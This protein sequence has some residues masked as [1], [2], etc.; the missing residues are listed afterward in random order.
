MGLFHE[1]G[2][3]TYLKKPSG[4]T[5][6]ILSKEAQEENES[7]KEMG[8]MMHWEMVTPQ[9]EDPLFVFQERP[10]CKVEFYQPSCWLYSVPN[11]L[12]F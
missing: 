12:V 1:R 5:S 10:S 4:S 3:V 7:R 2:R 11:L 8:E 9:K 6:P